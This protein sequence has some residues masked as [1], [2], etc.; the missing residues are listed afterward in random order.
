MDLTSWHALQLKTHSIISMSL[1]NILPKWTLYLLSLPCLIAIYN[2]SRLI[3]DTWRFYNF[4]ERVYLF[5]LLSFN[6]CILLFCTFTVLASLPTAPA[7][8]ALFVFSCRKMRAGHAH[9]LPMV[10]LLPG[11]FQWKHFTTLLRL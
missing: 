6:N 5:A 10:R 3:E 8:C 11:C 1:E 7:F 2:S 9:Q 4:N